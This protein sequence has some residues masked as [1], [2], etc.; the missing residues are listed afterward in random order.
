MTSDRDRQN[1]QLALEAYQPENE[2]EKGFKIKMKELLKLQNCFERS[3]LHAH[4]TG[5]AWVI[6]RQKQ[7]VLLTHHAKLN[8][9]L[10]LG[11]HADGDS[12]MARVAQKELSEESGRTDFKMLSLQ[13]F[14]IDI[15]TIPGKKDVPEHEH[16]DVR[17]LF[18]GNSELPLEK[19]HESNALAWVSYEELS[20]QVD[21]ND[22]IMRML[23]K[24]IKRI[25]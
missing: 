18:Y 4:F 11:G 14:D 16:F 3:L 21:G 9:W 6:D 15:H 23:S 22:S 10:Q 17:Y 8:R 24:T 19:N 7:K 20:A 5:S 12:N 13:I 25:H 1:F 2:S